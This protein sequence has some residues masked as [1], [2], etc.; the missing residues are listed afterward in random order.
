MCLLS[1]CIVRSIGRRSEFS[2]WI[3]VQVVLL[4]SEDDM[5]VMSGDLAVGVC[6]LALW[7]GYGC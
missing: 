5:V 7:S 1:V 2:A 3:V 6:C 4:Y